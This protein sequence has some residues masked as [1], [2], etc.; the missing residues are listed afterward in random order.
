[1][2]RKHSF[3]PVVDRNT[4]VLILGSLPGEESL[5][6]ARYY[7]HPQNRFWNLIG[8]AI[9][10]EL[11]PLDY[12]ARLAALLAHRIGL[13][14]VIA[15]A[16][17]RGSLDSAI[18]DPVDNDLVALASSLPDL[19]AIAFNGGRAARAGRL[20]LGAEA[21]RFRLVDLPSSS[22]AYA[23]MTLADKQARWAVIGDIAEA[24]PPRQK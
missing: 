8:G 16:C 4:R 12:D 3:P 24:S 20:R 21:D 15:H 14:D 6:Q 22:P 5:R 7:A 19:R 10:A 13:W 9:G 2:S 23:A 17:R 1:M 11:R 18:R